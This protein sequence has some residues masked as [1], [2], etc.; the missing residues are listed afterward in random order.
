M[1]AAHRTLA[2]CPFS[3]A[4]RLPVSMSHTLS[5][6]QG[7]ARLSPDPDTTRRPSGKKA[8]PQTYNEDI[9]S[10]EYQ[11]KP[12]ARRTESLSPFSDD[13]HS[14][15][16]TSHT[17]RFLP[18][19]PETM[20]RPSGETATQVTYDEDRSQNVQKADAARRTPI[21]GDNFFR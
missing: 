8:S 15:L 9:S 16:A 12:T 20:R 10:Q 21:Y 13:T 14:P 3:V 1:D 5:V 19:D 11:K 6:P 2:E 4:T 17:L 18:Y 7:R